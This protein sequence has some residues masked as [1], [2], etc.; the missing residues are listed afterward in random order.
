[1]TL[2]LASLVTLALGPAV[3]ALARRSSAMLDGLDGFVY[4]AIGGLV[5]LYVL[6]DA[7]VRAGWWVVPAAAIGLAGPSFVERRIQRSA[8]HAHAAALVLACV[9]LGLHGLLDGIALVGASDA[10]A[11][12]GSSHS[13]GSGAG[14][15][16]AIVLHRLPVGVMV[17]WLVQPAYGAA[18]AACSLVG[19]ALATVGGFALG[20]ALLG[21][22]ATLPMG[23]FM[24]LVGGSLLHVVLHQSHPIQPVPGVEPHLSS[25]WPSW[26]TPGGLG[27]AVGTLLLLVLHEAEWSSAAAA[28]HD[29][30]G[31][32]TAA[33]FLHLALASAP[34]LVLAYGMAG[35]VQAFLPKASMDWLGRGTG[36]GQAARGVA[37]GLPLPICS[38][39]VI[40]V[41][42][43]L[44]LRGAP[45][46][47]AMAFLV[48]T[49]ELGLDAV[50]LSVPLLGGPMTVARVVCATLVAL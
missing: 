50:L 28:S 29:H 23:L 33:L 3:L 42:R 37:F 36:F 41:Y 25:Q 11:A 10:D 20:P 44:V 24:A 5:V 16:L 31:L 12:H 14:L 7:Y 38:C 27:A 49:P 48:A 43:S 8:H 22:L 9:A 17:W 1:M 34:A 15:A 6:P 47:A 30:N 13:H 19:V 32:G 26:L 21:A 46:S 39:G 18:A 4:V 2:L 45:P 40:P 35:L